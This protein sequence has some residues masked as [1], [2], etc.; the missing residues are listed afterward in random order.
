MK[1][2][3][4]VIDTALVLVA[5]SATIILLVSDIGCAN[6]P[7]QAPP[8]VSTAALG[9]SITKAKSSVAKAKASAGKASVSIQQAQDTASQM[10]ADGQ[11][12]LKYLKGQ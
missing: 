5:R 3:L 1:L 7:V 11:T 8:V 2:V 6:R 4:L 9:A 12:V 10:D